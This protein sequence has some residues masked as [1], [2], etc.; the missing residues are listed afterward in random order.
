M[1]ERCAGRLLAVDLGQ[2]RIGLALSDP[3]GIT[4]QPLETLQAIGPKRDLQNVAEVAREH[5]ATTVVVG[6]P[7]LLSGED[8]EAARGA[9]AF[10]EGLGRRL[11]GVRIALWDERLTTVQAER[12]MIAGNAR[13]SRRR[14]AIDVVAAVII[15]QSFLDAGA[16]G[17]GG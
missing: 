9:R 3:L 2:V 12:A 1:T 17:E 4:A 15:L 8:G 11:P 16:G 14:E 6:L 7:L 13:R 5:E 10:A